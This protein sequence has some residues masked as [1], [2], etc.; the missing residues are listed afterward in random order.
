MI[1]L[2]GS[3]GYIGEAYRKY[4]DS[5]GRP[6][7]TASV[8]Y[9]LDADS[10]L[11]TLRESRVS[12]VINCAAYT[13]STSI[14]DC[15]YHK[16]TAFSA[17]ALLPADIQNVCSKAGCKLA[18]ISTGCIFNDLA[19]AQG[20]SPNAQ[21]SEFSRGSDH[22]NKY[23]SWYS[24]TKSYGEN[25]LRTSNTYI[26]RVRLPFNGAIDRRN[27]LYKIINYPR[28]LNATN[29]YTNLDEF[30]CRSLRLISKGEIGTYNAVQPGYMNTRE[31]VSILH[32][33]GLVDEK[34]YFS[35]FAEFSKCVTAIR[36]NCVLSNTLMPMDSIE[37]SINQA[38][39]EYGKNLSL[40]K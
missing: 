17:N 19:C 21:F 37:Q 11:H 40:S 2:L 35:D 20:K 24:Y 18:H 30:V 9:P 32:D 29:S 27:I 23:Q 4:L 26:F 39:I 22:F 14:D 8:R 7:I 33:H 5:I 12:I 16:W 6:Y 10:L 13:G 3:S 31:I 1:C 34:V 28:L 15:E 38:A 36:S 25:R